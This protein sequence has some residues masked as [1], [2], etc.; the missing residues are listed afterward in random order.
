M[1]QRFGRAAERALEEGN[2][3]EAEDRAVA[4]LL[5]DPECRQA[6]DVHRHVA[7]LRE[8]GFPSAGAKSE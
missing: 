4:G 6:E 2:L 7:S 1:A 8:Q 5:I 3:D